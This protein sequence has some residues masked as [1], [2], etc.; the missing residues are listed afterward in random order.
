VRS[1]KNHASDNG[2]QLVTRFQAIEIA[3]QDQRDPLI[4]ADAN[5]RTIDIDLATADALPAFINFRHF[6]DPSFGVSCRVFYKIYFTG[7]LLAYD[8]T[9]T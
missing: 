4:L 2:L 5:A 7:M 8:V 6:L 3:G 9:Y 1:G